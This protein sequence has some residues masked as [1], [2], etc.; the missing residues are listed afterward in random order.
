VKERDFF[1]EK[2]YIHSK[3]SP[4]YSAIFSTTNFLCHQ[5]TFPYPYHFPDF[6]NGFPSAVSGTILS[7]TGGHDQG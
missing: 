7:F 5:D 4:L 2:V 6:F 1:M 3:D